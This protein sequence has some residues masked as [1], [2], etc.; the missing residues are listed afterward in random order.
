M[1]S[2]S[3]DVILVRGKIVAAQ[4]VAAKKEALRLTEE[5]IY[6]RE[7]HALAKTQERAKLAP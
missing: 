5:L 4:L 3:S 2:D 7:R 1:S 6:L